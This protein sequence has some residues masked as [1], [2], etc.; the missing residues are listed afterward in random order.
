MSSMT[1]TKAK[2]KAARRRRG[3]DTSKISLHGATAPNPRSQ[4]TRTKAEDPRKVALTKRAADCGVDAKEASLAILGHDLGRCIHKLTSGDERAQII[5]T[6]ETISACH[7]NWRLRY[8][9]QTGDAKGANIG[10]VP[11][12]METDTSL[13]VDMRTPEEKA[14]QAVTSWEAWRAKINALPAPQMKRAIR[15]VLEGF[16]GEAIIWRDAAP[17]PLGI[18][19]VKA[20]RMLGA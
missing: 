8:V 4:G 11:E 17:T 5:D 15:G 12:P 6:W 7:R 14:A 10:M 13:R 16:L 3:A 20:L 2:S 1:K 9:G 18:V 19:A